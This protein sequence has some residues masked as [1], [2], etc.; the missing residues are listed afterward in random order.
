MEATLDPW[1][2]KKHQGDV[3]CW[4]VDD[5]FHL[6]STSKATFHRNNLAPHLDL[7]FCSG[8]LGQRINERARSLMR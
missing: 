1:L 3:S 2:M 7:I 8:V 6:G 4:V 5:D